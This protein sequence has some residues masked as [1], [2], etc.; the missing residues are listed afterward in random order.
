MEAK[1]KEEFWGVCSV[2][3][4]LCWALQLKYQGLQACGSGLI[5][6][7]SSSVTSPFS[8]CV[9]EILQYDVNA[10]TQYLLS[11]SRSYGM[12]KHNQFGCPW[13]VVHVLT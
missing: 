10:C 9:M 8:S 4:G 7:Q 11:L 1:L 6:H 5:S 12:F 3:V 2:V 13:F